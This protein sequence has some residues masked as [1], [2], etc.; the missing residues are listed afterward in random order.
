[1]PPGRHGVVHRQE[2]GASVAGKY[3]MGDARYFCNRILDDV[4]LL[5]ITL[6]RVWTLWHAHATS[7]AAKVATSDSQGERPELNSS[8][9]RGDY[10]RLC[11][12]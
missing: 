11:A 5:V 12:C 6:R 7:S 8:D 3:C 1:M 4:H 10:C 2:V 9:Q